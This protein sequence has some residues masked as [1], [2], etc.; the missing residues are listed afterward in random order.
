M[1]L[2]VSLSGKRLD[3]PLACTNVYS[4]GLGDA[5]ASGQ[6]DWEPE[7]RDRA[8]RLQAQG[9]NFGLLFHF[10]GDPGLSKPVR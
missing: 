4:F 3:L 2:I 6:C 7:K 1:I 9:I 10:R 5:T 8:D